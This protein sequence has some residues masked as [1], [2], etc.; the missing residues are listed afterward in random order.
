MDEIKVKVVFYASLR[1]L[2]GTRELVL[3]LDNP[4]FDFLIDKLR[5]VLGCKAE[6]ILADDRTPRR[7][8]LFSVNGKLMT[9]AKLERLKLKDG[10]VIDIMP[11][12]SGG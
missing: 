3:E 5:Q 6:Y 11:P 1:E 9:L 8:L 7:T 4:G 12:P 10:D 2:I